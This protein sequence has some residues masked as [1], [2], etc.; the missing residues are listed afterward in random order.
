M[1]DNKEFLL[2][3]EACKEQVFSCKRIIRNSKE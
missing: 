1:E 3:K 2:L